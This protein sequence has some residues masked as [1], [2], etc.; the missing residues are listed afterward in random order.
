[1]CMGFHIITLVGRW[2]PHSSQ[3]AHQAGAY[4]GFCS[5]KRLGVF[6]LSNGWCQRFFTYIFGARGP[7]ARD[8]DETCI[9]RFAKF[10]LSSSVVVPVKVSGSKLFKWY[11]MLVY[12]KGYPQISRYYSPFVRKVSCSLQNSRHCLRILGKQRRKRGE[13]EKIRISLFKLFG[14]RHTL[15]DELITA[16]EKQW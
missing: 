3:V 11:G 5:M 16:L 9:W 2:S 6:L 7:P 4:P 8:R 10:S 12:R 1:M 14:P 13:R 15:N